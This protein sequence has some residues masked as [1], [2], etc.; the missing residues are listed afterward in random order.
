MNYWARH[1]SLAA[2]AV[3][4]VGYAATTSANP[5]SERGERTTTVG[6]ETVQRAIETV[7]K[8]VGA[9][10]PTLVP[11]WLKAAP[12]GMTRPQAKDAV[13]VYLVQS[14][15]DSLKSPASVPRRCRCIFVRPEVAKRWTEDN[16]KGTGRLQLD[17]K[18]FLVFVL[19]HEVGH[20]AQS[21]RGVEFSE[22]DQSM[23]NTERNAMKKAEEE[24]DDF[25]A[26]VLRRTAKAATVSST[27]LDANW[28]VNELSK[29]S[30]NMQAFRTLDEFGAFSIGKPSVFF[31]G[32]YTHP[33]LALRVL[34][35]NDLI[36][37]TDETR[38]LLEAFKEARERGRKSQQAQ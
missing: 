8:L 25:A 31:D 13:F 21:T 28:V 11:A 36:H 26:A 12:A 10:G 19:L 18:N 35:V 32:D 9:D 7:N 20:L 15:P 22:L 37:S 38:Y 30:W 6:Q 2:I 1:I 4:L 23:L 27:S 14:A 24:A 16:S 17:E 34:R 33:N 5:V 3:L 29:M